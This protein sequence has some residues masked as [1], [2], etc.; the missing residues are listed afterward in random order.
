MHVKNP[1]LDSEFYSE[2]AWQVK[3][4]K[5]YNQFQLIYVLI[6]QLFFYLNKYF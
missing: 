4:R 6:H 2:F 1:E 3:P 5:I